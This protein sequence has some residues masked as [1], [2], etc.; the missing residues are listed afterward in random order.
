MSVKD[1]SA[2]KFDVLYNKRIST[3][4]C[5]ACHNHG[6][7]IIVNLPL[8][9]NRANAVYVKCKHCGF[10]SG[11]HSAVACF[12]DTEQ[13]RYGSFVIEKSLMHAIYSAVEEWNGERRENGN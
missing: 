11:D 7:E 3:N 1:V 12:H 10:S 4:S 13:N 6:T 8:Y 2:K 5:P 9:G